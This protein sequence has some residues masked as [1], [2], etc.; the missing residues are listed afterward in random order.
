MKIVIAVGIILNAGVLSFIAYQQNQQI[1]RGSTKNE[2]VALLKIFEAREVDRG[3]TLEES[4]GHPLADKIDKLVALAERAEQ[5][6]VEEAKAA[7]E[8]EET[9]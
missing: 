2:V 4:G 6:E 7:K 3:R 5:R 1:T 8:P 9:E